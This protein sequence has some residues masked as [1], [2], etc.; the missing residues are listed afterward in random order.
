MG[1]VLGSYIYMAKICGDM[2]QR[3]LIVCQGFHTHPQDSWKHRR[4]ART[5]AL[6]SLYRRRLPAA[7]PEKAMSCPLG[8][9][10]AALRC[11]GPFALMCARCRG[12]CTTSTG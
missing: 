10:A 4:A 9:M 12:S 3:R 8:E 2:H 7:A 5:S 1:G 6:D 11:P